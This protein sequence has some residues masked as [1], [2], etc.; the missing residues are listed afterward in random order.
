M[1]KPTKTQTF[2]SWEGLMSAV[3]EHEHEL[4]GVTPFYEELATS[5]A[6]ALNL[7]SVRDGL[8]ASA[9]EANQ[10]LKRAIA[11]GNEAAS[12]LRLFVRSRLG[13][14]SRKLPRFGMKLRRPPKSDGEV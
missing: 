4:P 10:S 8:Y 2:K 9:E 14:Y 12:C 6:A 1:S 7:M 3:V 11:E 13:L 5:R